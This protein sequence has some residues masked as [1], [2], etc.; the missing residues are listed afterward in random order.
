MTVSLKTSTILKEFY[1]HQIVMDD[2]WFLSD[3]MQ[4]RNEMDISMDLYRVSVVLGALLQTS[5]SRFFSFPL[6]DIID[7]NCWFATTPAPILDLQG[8]RVEGV[9]R[10]AWP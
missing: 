1:S 9:D 7:H 5:E 3:N 4:V 10:T 8:V 2:F 6:R